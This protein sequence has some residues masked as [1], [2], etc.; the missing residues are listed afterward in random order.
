MIKAKMKS[1]V[2]I[3]ATAL[4][5]VAASADPTLLVQCKK[6]CEN[7]VH[8][9]NAF[10]SSL[11]YG[12][13][14]NEARNGL[15]TEAYNHGYSSQGTTL[16]KTVGQNPIEQVLRGL[17]LFDLYFSTKVRLEP[18]IQNIEMNYAVLPMTA[19][20]ANSMEPIPALDHMAKTMSGLDG[21]IL[22]FMDDHARSY[23]ANEAVLRKGMN[24]KLE[25]SLGSIFPQ[26][27]RGP[28]DKKARVEW[29]ARSF[30]PLA[31]EGTF[32][33]PKKMSRHSVYFPAIGRP[34]IPDPKSKDIVDVNA[35]KIQGW[36]TNDLPPGKFKPTVLPNA[37]VHRIT[38]SKDSGDIGRLIRFEAIK[39]FTSP[40]FIDFSATF[41]RSIAIEK[42]PATFTPEHIIPMDADKD[43][44]MARK[45]P[46]EV[47]SG[48]PNIKDALIAHGKII[49]QPGYL[50]KFDSKRETL[51]ALTSKIHFQMG[52]H[53]LYL[54][55]KRAVQLTPGEANLAEVFEADP[56]FFLPTLDKEKSI[57][58]VR[59][60]FDYNDLAGFSHPDLPS[61]LG[62]LLAKALTPSARF[63]LVPSSAELFTCKG[64]SASGTMTLGL[65]GD[66]DDA[67]APGRNICE[68]TF[69]SYSDF[70][71]F[72]NSKVMA[73]VGDTMKE[74]VDGG[75]MT[76]EQ[77][78]AKE[79]AKLQDQ[80][81]NG[82]KQ[83][84][85]MLNAY[86]KQ[87]PNRK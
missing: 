24:A 33:V 2:A 25:A 60:W 57:F 22:K 50:K 69:Q 23:P 43:V 42:L 74:Q 55:V 44:I 51:N 68:K 12:I 18:K 85:S 14:V 70:Q 37:T 34:E 63:S 81:L 4:I 82:M 46:R 29:L 1:L 71:A 67:D 3:G 48:M 75:M 17:S 77:V 40:D 47:G 56:G 28:S 45:N 13:A 6:N 83:T 39:D 11:I 21:G 79:L 87:L 58:T 84:K 8:L 72:V 32:S 36:D 10:S 9:G 31:A 64:G 30:M 35:W 26:D 27:Y 52:I 54:R 78:A 15:G 73:T 65:S 76:G 20:E 62:N 86:G 5:G 66:D 53:K 80:I 38:Y 59:V 7:L 41:G 61:G 16:E 49:F 19:S